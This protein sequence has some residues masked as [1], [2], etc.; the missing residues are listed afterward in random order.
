MQ[1]MVVAEFSLRTGERND[2]AL[3]REVLWYGLPSV[4]APDSKRSAMECEYVTRRA[5]KDVETALSSGEVMAT[6]YWDAQGLLHLEFVQWRETISAVR[7][8]AT[9][10]IKEAVRGKRPPGQW[11]SAGL[12]ER[13]KT[14]DPRENL[15]TRGIVRH[16][17]H[18]RKSGSDPAGDWARFALV[19]G[20]L[21]NRPASMAPIVYYNDI[22]TE[23]TGPGTHDPPTISR[24]PYPAMGASGP[25]KLYNLRYHAKSKKREEIIRLILRQAEQLN[26]ERYPDRTPRSDGCFPVALSRFVKRAIR[27]HNNAIVVE[28]AQMKLARMLFSLL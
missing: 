25:A 6:V 13:G 23:S 18:L 17:S 26:R 11:S 10:R 27:T 21:S 28:L 8:T 20:E 16:D 15:A 2:I 9:S 7:F 1:M 4:M 14:G 24:P 22:K 19:G 5:R 3:V 12:Q